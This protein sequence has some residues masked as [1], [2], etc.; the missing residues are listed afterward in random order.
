MAYDVYPSVDGVTKAFPP[1]VRAAIAQ[2]TEVTGMVDGKVNSQFNNGVKPRLEN[3][4][5]KNAAQDEAT[6]PVATLAE[7]PAAN[8]DNR[9]LVRFVT[10]ENELYYS[11]GTTWSFISDGAQGV[12]GPAGA[13][14][15]SGGEPLQIIRNNSVGTTTE[16][17]TL[18]AAIA[19]TAMGYLIETVDGYPARGDA[20]MAI[21]RG[22]TDPR[23]SEQF[24]VGLDLWA[25]SNPP[26]P[27]NVTDKWFTDFSTE[28]VGAP[29]VGWTSRWEALASHNVVMD[30]SNKVLQIR[31]NSGYTSMAL[32][33]WDAVP[34]SADFEIVAKVRFLV[35]L[36]REDAFPI[37]TVAGRCQ[38]SVDNTDAMGYFAKFTNGVTIPSI[39][40]YR[41]Q[42]GA[43]ANLPVVAVPVE[44]HNDLG[45][46]WVRLRVIGDVI[47]LRSWA[48]GSTEPTTWSW[49]GVDATI[50][51]AGRVGL[52]S[53][54]GGNGAAYDVACVG[55]AINGRTAPVS[56]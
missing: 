6:S 31:K 12:P 49:T 50:T 4:E 46:N 33:S 2:A 43:H 3:L 23:E 24:A 47:S 16:W 5:N 34:V 11:N 56:A 1:A 18:S 36:I 20:H 29:P 30:G 35:T 51:G 39:Q 54:S 40:G 55:V 14:V 10:S 42:P 38:G 19:D 26:V 22:A 48:D 21:W 13:G 28:T 15:P 9:G 44:S 17:V 45:W 32:L 52:G 8:S 27:P 41:R 53:Y 37:S 7:L 25:P